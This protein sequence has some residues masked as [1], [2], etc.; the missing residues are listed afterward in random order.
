[1]IQW[2]TEKPSELARRFLIINLGG[3]YKCFPSKSIRYNFVLCDFS[4]FI[5]YFTKKNLRGKLLN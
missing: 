1:M 3:G 4:V 5:L 2:G